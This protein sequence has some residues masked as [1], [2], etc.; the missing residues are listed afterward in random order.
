MEYI[1]KRTFKLY[2]IVPGIGVPSESVLRLLTE[3]II[4]CDKFT[5]SVVKGQLHY[6]AHYLG[7]RYLKETIDFN[8]RRVSNRSRS[9]KSRL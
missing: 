4:L 9:K 7:S 2:T 1:N 8:G 5:R 6:R 3:L